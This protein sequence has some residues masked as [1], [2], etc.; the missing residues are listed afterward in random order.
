M[1]HWLKPEDNEAIRSDPESF[2]QSKSDPKTADDYFALAV[3]HDFAG[4]RKVSGPLIRRALQLDFCHLPSLY[5]LALKAFERRRE[6][7]AKTIFRRVIRMDKEATTNTLAFQ[8]EL[9]FALPNYEDAG[10]WGVWCLEELEVFHKSSLSTKFQL[11]KTLFE[12]S[13]LKEAIPY[14]KAALSSKELS[15]EATEYL[16]YIYE[17]IYRGTDLIDQILQ[18]AEEVSER[19]DLFFNLAMVCQHDQKRLDLAM[20][21]FYL[22]SREDPY[23]PGLRFSLEQAAV[24]FIGAA[25]RRSSKT[26]P[27]LVMM[28]H[29]YQGAMGVARKYADDLKNIEYPE[30]FQAFEPQSLWSRWLLKDQGVLGHSLKAWFGPQNSPVRSITGRVS[31]SDT[32]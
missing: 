24:E 16:S 7:E 3:A 32:R 12:Q 18:L 26:D 6:N 17:H 25:N 21:F 5:L 19:S 11:G 30:T 9:K 22:A 13:R 14:L 4:R 1:I 29:I 28:A 31:Q 10:R 23:D 27:L 2:I 20:H 8:K 15:T